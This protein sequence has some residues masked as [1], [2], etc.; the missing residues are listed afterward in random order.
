MPSLV[1]KSKVEEPYIVRRQ[2]LSLQFYWAQ[3][4]AVTSLR[5]TLQKAQNQ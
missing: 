5:G 2:V 4:P 1:K 3:G